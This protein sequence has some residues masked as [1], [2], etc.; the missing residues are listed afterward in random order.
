MSAAELDMDPNVLIDRVAD[1]EATQ[2]E[3][4]VETAHQ[5]FGQNLGQPPTEE[6]IECYIA[7]LKNE[8]ERAGKT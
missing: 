6:A 3:H 7:V 5:I 4:L 8:F 1:L 2:V